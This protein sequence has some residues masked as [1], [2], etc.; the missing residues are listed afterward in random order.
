MNLAICSLASS[1][2][3]NCHL[4]KSK[5]TNIILDCGI[6][7]SKIREDLKDLG[8]DVKEIDAILI[9]HE[10]SD[11]IKG[12]KTLMKKSDKASVYMTDGTKN[13]LIKKSDYDEERIITINPGEVFTV[14]DISIEPIR[15]SHDTPDPVAYSFKSEDKQISVVTDTGYVTEEIFLGIKDSDILVI[16]S[17]HERNILLAGSYPYQIK[18]R[19][20]SDV[21][22]LSNEICAQT[23]LRI[24][25]NLD[26]SKIPRVVLAHLSKE[27]NTPQQAMIT[28][29]NIL[30][31]E[32]YYIGKDVEIAVANREIRGEI[33]E[34]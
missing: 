9:T 17:N 4:I 27:N 14:G 10:H 24:L 28:V 7:V 3:G 18:Y 16:E 22:H 26:G 19:I 23:I 5:N 30:E 21:G 20:L 34:I 11:H 1:S 6:S 8:V 12:L 33:L 15:V 32:G 25:K 13:E 29:R 2:S 31:E